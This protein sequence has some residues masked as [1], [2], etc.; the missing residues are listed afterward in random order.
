M[1]LSTVTLDGV[2]SPDSKRAHDFLSKQW[3]KCGSTGNTW[4]DTMTLRFPISSRWI[5]GR[6]WSS[7]MGVWY[8]VR[9]TGRLEGGKHCACS[10]ICNLRSS[11]FEQIE[12][13]ERERNTT[14]SICTLEIHSDTA[15]KILLLQSHDRAIAASW[16]PIS[17]IHTPDIRLLITYVEWNCDVRI[18][19]RIWLGILHRDWRC[20]LICRHES[21]M[22]NWNFK[23]LLLNFE[24][25]LI[26]R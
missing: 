7:R 3:S 6:E 13:V 9:M 14:V 16:I 4:R 10:L 23:N 8:W 18:R 5:V 20:G 22:K 11:V 2:N 25:R 24:I 15:D 1:V 21:E 12:V 19:H 26:S 17:H